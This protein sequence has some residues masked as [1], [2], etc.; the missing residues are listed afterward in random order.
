[1]AANK[2]AKII[3][4]KAM[5]KILVELWWSMVEYGQCKKTFES[6]QIYMALIHRS[7]LNRFTSGPKLYGSVNPNHGGLLIGKKNRKSSVE[8]TN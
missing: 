5:E 3:F 1:M 8:T 7:P 2:S 4:P 6:D